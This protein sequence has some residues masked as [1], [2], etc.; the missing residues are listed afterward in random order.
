[1]AAPVINTGLRPVYCPASS[2]FTQHTPSLRQH[3]PQLSS[4]FFIHT[5]HSH[6][7]TT[8]STTIFLL[9]HSH[10]TLP[11]YD[12][13]FHNYLPSSSFTLPHSHNN[14][15]QHLPRTHAF[16]QLSSL[17]I[18]TPTL[19]QQPTTTLQ[20]LPRTHTFAQHVR[21]VRRHCG[22]VLSYFLSPLL[23]SPTAIRSA[24]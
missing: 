16:P 14:Q 18:N 2:S 21:Q 3:L 13:T 5:T 6:T 7:T 12:N 17:F 11:H 10:N 24:P 20:R 9:L 4:F 8:P 22:R 19:P 23:S 1:L 15:R